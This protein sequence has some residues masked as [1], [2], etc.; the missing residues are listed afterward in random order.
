MKI[1]TEPQE[2]IDEHRR[3]MSN[4]AWHASYQYALKITMEGE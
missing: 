1:E 4:E 3:D 2:A